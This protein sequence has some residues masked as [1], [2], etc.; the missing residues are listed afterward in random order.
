MPSAG[1]SAHSCWPEEKVSRETATAG[2]DIDHEVWDMA[3]ADQVKDALGALPD[4]LRR[5]ILLAYFG[6]NT[7]REVAQILDEPEGTV[8]SRIRSGLGRL[9]INLAEL[10]VEPAGAES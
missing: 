3:V 9:R 2:Y 7:Y 8:K 6:G 1:P 5:P 10:G 4:D